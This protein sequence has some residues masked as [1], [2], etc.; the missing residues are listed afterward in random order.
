[1]PY[2][3]L[4]RTDIPDG[5]VQ[6][7]DLM[8]NTSQRSLIYEPPGQTRYINRAVNETPQAT[9]TGTVQADFNGLS[10][11]LADRVEPGGTGIATG[12]LSLVGSAPFPGAFFIKGIPFDA[13][14]VPRAPGTQ[15][16]D[17]VTGGDIGGAAELIAAIMDPATQALLLAAGPPGVSVLAAPGPNPW[18]VQLICDTPGSIGDLITLG[19]GAPPFI[20]SGPTLLRSVSAWTAANLASTSAS[21]LARVDAGQALTLADVN[22]VLAA[23]DSELTNAGGSQSSGVLTE[24][25]SVMAGRGYVLPAGSQKLTGGAWAAPQAGNFTETRREW[26]TTWV[27]GEY[28]PSSLANALAGGDPVQ[29]ETKPVRHTYDGTHF[30]ISLGSGHLA[31]FQA[32][33]TLFPDSDL[34]GHYPWLMQGTNQFPQVDN[35]RVVTVYNDDGSLA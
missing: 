18:E 10:A 15:D 5:T 7:L 14:P 1:M 19:S 13:I 3:C 16:F 6:I 8:P 2:I 29:V 9:P 4:A 25:L 35:A 28:V 32:G 31:S 26:G 20:I 12:L 23:V 34:V 11:Y 22:T 30:Q 27:D 21:L 24:L 17:V 33:V